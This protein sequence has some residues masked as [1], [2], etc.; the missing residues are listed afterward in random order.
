[1]TAST[2]SGSKTPTAT[3]SKIYLNGEEISLT[4]YNINGN[5]YF[6]LRD[7]MKIFDVYVGWDGK[8]STI[9]LDTS[10]GYTD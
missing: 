7:I 8:T 2:T 5:N 4:A 1:M 3:T 9:T 6:K 10:K